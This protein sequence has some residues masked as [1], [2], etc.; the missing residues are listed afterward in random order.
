MLRTSFESAGAGQ[1][2]P[3]VP[4]PV[5]RTREPCTGSRGAREQRPDKGGASQ[6]VEGGTRAARRGPAP[7]TRVVS[8]GRSHAQ[9]RADAR[10][11]ACHRILTPGGSYAPPPTERE[12]FEPAPVSVRRRVNLRKDTSEEPSLARRRSPAHGLGSHGWP[13][14]R[15]HRVTRPR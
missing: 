7:T 10:S 15:G 8:S 2:L 13:A 4:A 1:T 14:L 9:G 3:S 6:Q 5:R 11:R 12:V